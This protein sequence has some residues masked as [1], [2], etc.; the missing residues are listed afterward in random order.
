MY[1]AQLPRRSLSLTTA[2]APFPADVCFALALV[3]HPLPSACANAVRA[4]LH[5]DVLV[6]PAEFRRLK[7]PEENSILLQAFLTAGAF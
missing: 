1:Y 3:A 2:I 7:Q 4:L 5:A 6:Q